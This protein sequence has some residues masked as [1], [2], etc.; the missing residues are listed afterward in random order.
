ML[1]GKRVKFIVNPEAGRGK[2]RKVDSILHSLLK[3][4]GIDYELEKTTGELQAIRMAK[5]SAGKFDAVVAVGGD[6]TSNEVANGLIGSNT[7]MGV[8]P[9]GS[10]NDFA[11]MLGMKDNIE[12]CVDQI[13]EGRTERIDTGA[14]R[15][16]DGARQVT[17]RKFVNSIGIGF[18]AVVA[19]ESRQ[20]KNLKGVPLYFVSVLRSLRKLKP[21]LFE[22]QTNGRSE[23]QEYYLVCVG[24]GNR[25]GGGFYVTPKA[26]PSDGMF[27]V[28]TVRQVGLLRAL[29][30]LPTILSGSH[31]RFKEVDFFNADKLSVGSK[32]PFVVHCD[33]E[34]LGVNNSKAEVELHPGSLEVIVG[35]NGL[36]VP[37]LL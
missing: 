21:H 17:T 16:E 10:G 31:G 12:H 3:P 34:I 28:C 37:S 33:G 35:R 2:S 22:M 29:R 30:I 25:E 14:V 8:I 9:T 26:N 13:F 32:R 24:N 4:R 7:A 20:I 36:A 18:D 6:G 19:Y 5:E 27:E 11:V 23:T 15:L 1:K